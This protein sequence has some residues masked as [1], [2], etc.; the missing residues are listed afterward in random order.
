MKLLNKIKNVLCRL[1][2]GGCVTLE[3]VLGRTGKA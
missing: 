3:K 2:E 1:E